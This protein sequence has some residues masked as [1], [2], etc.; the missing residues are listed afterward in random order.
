MAVAIDLHDQLSSRAVKVEGVRPQRMLLPELQSL[1]PLPQEHPQAVLGRC[2]RPPEFPGSK[3]G[4][5]S[6]AP[7]SSPSHLPLHHASHGP[8]P[9][10]FAAGRQNGRHLPQ[11]QHP[12]LAFG[13]GFGRVAAYSAASSQPERSLSALANLA[14][15]PPV[16]SSKLRLPLPSASALAKALRRGR[17]CSS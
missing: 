7:I 1:G 6:V 13:F 16:H 8:P 14:A 3:D 15:V 11:A 12:H 4:C 2:R 10:R 9:R 17:S 5:V